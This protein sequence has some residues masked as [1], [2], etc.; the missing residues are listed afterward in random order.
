M[1]VC[2]LKQQG[3]KELLHS[4]LVPEH[5]LQVFACFLCSRKYCSE[6]HLGRE[7]WPSRD[8][9]PTHCS[10]SKWRIVLRYKGAQRR[11]ITFIA[12]SDTYY[13]ILIVLWPFP[14]GKRWTVRQ[15]GLVGEQGTREKVKLWTKGQKF[16]G[17]RIERWGRGEEKWVKQTNRG[18]K[19]L[20]VKHREVKHSVLN[21]LFAMCASANSQRRE[22]R[23][24]GP[25]SLNVVASKGH[26][27]H[28]GHREPRA[29]DSWMQALPAKGGQEILGSGS[30]QK[31]WTEALKEPVLGLPGHWVLAVLANPSPY[32]SATLSG[33]FS[34]LRPKVLNWHPP[35]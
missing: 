33:V 16:E 32:Y 19:G 34:N 27:L 15:H 3:G 2:D 31:S 10:L 4:Q 29:Q 20:N 13:R 30:P 9:K 24:T 17:G 35:L 28:L 18:T 7:L 8:C 6:V 21:Y 14:H 25:P 12:G 11:Q 1:S 5:L 26:H 22:L 23:Q